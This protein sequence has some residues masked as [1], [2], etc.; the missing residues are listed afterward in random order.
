VKRYFVDS[1]KEVGKFFFKFLFKNILILKPIF[2]LIDPK[3]RS[4]I[5][6]IAIRII[7]KT[8]YSEGANTTFD[9]NLNKGLTLIGYPFVGI[10]EGEFLRQTAKAF[11]KVDVDVGIYDCNSEVRPNQKVKSLDCLVRSDNLYR[12]NIFHLKPDQAE[13]LV[14]SLGNS[15]FEGR[16]NIG[17]CLWEL[18]SFPKAWISTLNFFNEVWCPSRFI[19]STVSKCSA[20]PVVYMPPTFGIENSEEFDRA[21]FNLPKDRFL[22]LFIFDF[23]SYVSRKNPLGCIKAFQKAFSQNDKSVGLVLKCFGGNRY[24]DEFMFLT[25]A[26]QEDSR[27]NLIDAVFS[28]EEITGLMNVC[29][30]FVSLH[31]SE[32]IGLS[33]AQSMLL[34]KPVITTNYSGNVDF[35]KPGNSC[36]VDYNLIEVKKGEYPFFKG[37]VWAD[38]S[39]DQ[40]SSYMRRLVE[41]ESY[42]NAVAQSGCSYI[43]THHN[44]EVVGKNY[45]SRL[46]E[47]GLIDD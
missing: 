12:T 40:A 26:I 16:Y 46:I 15:F 11:L 28:S 22:F 7:F 34:G 3:V 42:R 13:A 9:S 8:L 18:S 19:Q 25:R 24:A 29:D 33:I 47:L 31:R 1:I 38:P 6:V 4:Y 43:K 23:K 10:G 37:Q 20:G 5:K 44:A 39:I 17:Y 2:I 36:L 14:I 35:T 41:D 27:I 45:R 21:Y 32:G 30:S